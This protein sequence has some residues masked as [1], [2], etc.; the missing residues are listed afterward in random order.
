MADDD[1]MELNQQLA[2][3]RVGLPYWVFGRLLRNV[4]GRKESSTMTPSARYAK[5]VA[6]YASFLAA[7]DE[8]VEGIVA[9]IRIGMPSTVAA[10]TV[11]A[12]RMGLDA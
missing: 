7:P 6:I 3:K 9:L 12:W 4:I 1:S 8:W 11:Q 10:V 2:R 5:A